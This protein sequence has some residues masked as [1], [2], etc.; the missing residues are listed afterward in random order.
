[1]SQTYSFANGPDRAVK[2]GVMAAHQYEQTLFASPHVLD[3]NRPWVKSSLW[4]CRLFTVSH[5]IRAGKGHITVTRFR[6][7]APHKLARN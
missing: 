5:W 3:E 6:H 2:A 1:M 4:Y 7:I